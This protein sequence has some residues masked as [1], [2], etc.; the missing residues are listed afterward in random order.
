MATGFEISQA[1]LLVGIDILWI[2]LPATAFLL[3]QCCYETH[4]VPNLSDF[5]KMKYT[6]TPG[7]FGKIDKADRVHQKG[8]LTDI[9]CLEMKVENITVFILFSSSYC[10]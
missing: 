4:L 5:K 2:L 6:L 1:F 7:T 10:S 3:Y 8:K 9:C